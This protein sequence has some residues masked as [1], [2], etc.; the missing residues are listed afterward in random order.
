MCMQMSISSKLNFTVL[1][2]CCCCVCVCVCVCVCARLC[3]LIQPLC[4]TYPLSSHHQVYTLISAQPVLNIFNQGL[5]GSYMIKTILFQGTVNRKTTKEYQTAHNDSITFYLKVYLSWIILSLN[6]TLRWA[7]C[8]V[9]FV[10]HEP[11]DKNESDFS[12]R[13]TWETEVLVECVWILAVKI[14]A[15]CSGAAMTAMQCLGI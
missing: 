15:Q 1:V 8:S 7:L 11:F 9:G 3:F 6:L 4:P 14:S 13:N 2:L 12:K 5:Q 10:L